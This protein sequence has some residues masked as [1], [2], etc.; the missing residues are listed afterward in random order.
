ME[1]IINKTDANPYRK[2][3]L[4]LSTKT[5]TKEWLLGKVLKIVTGRPL[6]ER[7]KIC[8]PYNYSNTNLNGR[9]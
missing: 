5:I 3:S 9:V 1:A 6:T 7:R 4:I 2:R 8:N